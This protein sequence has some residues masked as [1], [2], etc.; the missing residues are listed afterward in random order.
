MNQKHRFNVYWR[1]GNCRAI[2]VSSA[3]TTE[4]FIEH[5]SSQKE[6]NTNYKHHACPNGKEIGILI[7][8]KFEEERNNEQR[9]LLN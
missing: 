1:C 8:F 6:Y 3:V 9:R 5:R 4:S 7:P 2:V